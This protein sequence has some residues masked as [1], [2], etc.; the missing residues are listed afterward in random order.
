MGSIFSSNSNLGSHQGLGGGVFIYWLL[1]LGEFA[2]P[3][4]LGLCYSSL[5]CCPI[6]VFSIG[7][8][9]AYTYHKDVCCKL[10][11]TDTGGLLNLYRCFLYMYADLH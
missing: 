3:G 8:V 11:T 6:G 10:G 5:I 4:R 7:G 9:F 2:V 1:V